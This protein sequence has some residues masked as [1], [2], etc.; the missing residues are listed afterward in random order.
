MLTFI[1][2]H[3]EPNSHFVK[4]MQFTVADIHWDEEMKAFQFVAEQ[5]ESFSFTELEEITR[6]MATLRYVEVRWDDDDD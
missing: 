1:V 2:Y 5:G 6:Y 3:S 4:R